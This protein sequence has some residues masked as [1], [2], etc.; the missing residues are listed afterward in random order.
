[1]KT[2]AIEHQVEVYRGYAASYK[3]GSP[4]RK[5]CTE[6]ADQMEAELAAIETA[7]AAKDV[8]ITGLKGEIAWH[9]KQ[10]NYDPGCL[11][12]DGGGNTDWW[13]HYIRAEVDRCNQYWRDSFQAA[14][15]PDEARIRQEAIEEC[16]TAIEVLKQRKIQ[17][18]L[19]TMG[20]DDALEVVRS[21]KEEPCQSEK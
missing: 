7:L 8:E 14:L 21:L 20:I 12:D 2:D 19:I 1:M 9:S 18:T 6:A 11:N 4:E 13:M 15:T 10:T 3:E 16:K 5:D 17:D